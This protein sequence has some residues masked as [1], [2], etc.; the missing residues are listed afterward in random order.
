M[1]YEQEFKMHLFICLFGSL[2]LPTRWRHFVSTHDL[3]YSSC[4]SWQDRPSFVSGSYT[5]HMNTWLIYLFSNHFCPIRFSTTGSLDYITFFLGFPGDRVSTH[6]KT[7]N[8]NENKTVKIKNIMSWSTLRIFANFHV[9]LNSKVIIPMVK[10]PY[11]RKMLLI[12][13]H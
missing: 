13:P 11:P 10:G 6:F 1:R 12:L 8:E 2:K 4:D 9:V 7:S 3:G 5:A